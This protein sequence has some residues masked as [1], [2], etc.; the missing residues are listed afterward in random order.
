MKKRATNG[1]FLMVLFSLWVV[2]WVAHGSADKPWATADDDIDIY[3][4]MRAPAPAPLL[5]AESIRSIRQFIAI[6]DTQGNDLDITITDTY[7]ITRQDSAGTRQVHHG[8]DLAAPANSLIWWTGDG[9]A[10]KI[11]GKYHA[12]WTGQMGSMNYGYQIAIATEKENRQ[13]ILR[14]CHLLNGSD[15]QLWE[16]GDKVDAGVIL[17]KVGTSGRVPNAIRP[18]LHLEVFRQDENEFV[19]IDPQEFFQITLKHTLQAPTGLRIV[20]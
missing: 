16:S 5:D 7:G 6:R 8:W 17:A 9:M 18:H 13:Y 12:P 14:F 15:Y 20:R 2:P 1:L 4:S 19:R 3:Y 11:E 10:T